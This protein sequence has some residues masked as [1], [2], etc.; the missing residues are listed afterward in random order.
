MNAIGVTRRDLIQVA[1]VACAAA[2]DLV[3]GHDGP[4]EAALGEV[5]GDVLAE[6]QR[7]YELHGC[8][9]HPVEVWLVILMKQM[10]DVA[11]DWEEVEWPHPEA[12]AER[13]ET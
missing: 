8:Q 10:G 4:D 1:A 5:I 9:H 3:V 6:R 7:Q 11:R 12:A 13:R 2:Q